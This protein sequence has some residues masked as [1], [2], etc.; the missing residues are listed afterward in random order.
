MAEKLPPPVT[1]AMVACDSIWVEPI[2][3]KVSLLGILYEFGAVAFPA[4]YALIAVYVCLTDAH[5]EV[6]LELRLVDADDEHEP[7]F[8][9]EDEVDFS[10]RGTIIE[11]TVEVED[12]A[13]P[14][15][16]DY[17]LQLFANGQ[18]VQERRLT[19]HH[20]ED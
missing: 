16:G 17:S 13:F 8:H 12:I 4:A 6:L 15:P 11:W 1:L 19:V 2:S 20:T 14:A 3:G 5:G 10:D 18:F 9:A 7:L